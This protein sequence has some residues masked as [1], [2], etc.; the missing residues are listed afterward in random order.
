MSILAGGRR[1]VVDLVEDD[2]HTDAVQ[3]ADHG[4]EF[5]HAG[6]TVLVGGSGVGASGAIQCSGS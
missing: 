6:A 3:S 1:V 2:L 5:A 4:A